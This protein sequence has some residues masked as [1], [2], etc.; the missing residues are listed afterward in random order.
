MQKN[1]KS[2]CQRGFTLIELISVIIIL[3]ILA[4][5][6]V[7]R[8]FDM[9]DQAR[10]TAAR[11]ALSEGVAR[12]NLAYSQYI[13]NTNNKP[14]NVSSLAGTNLIGS[15]TLTSVNIGDYDISYEQAGTALTIKAMTKGGASTLA[16]TVVTWPN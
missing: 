14:A 13:L 16:T 8:Y 7:P 5:V 4:A 6:I 11:G 2:R 12:F 10:N 9:T 3:G 1:K 15:D